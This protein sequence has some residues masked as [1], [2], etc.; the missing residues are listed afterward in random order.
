MKMNR[1]ILEILGIET[2]TF[3]K[4][5]QCGV[6]KGFY[7]MPWDTQ[8]FIR[9]FECGEVALTDYNQNCKEGWEI[10]PNAFARILAY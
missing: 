3:D 10:N 8:A 2:D 5:M 4:I 6:C 9:C 1:E 7:A